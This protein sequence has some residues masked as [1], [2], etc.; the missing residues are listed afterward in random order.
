MIGGAGNDTYV[1]DRLAD[2]VSENLAR[3]AGVD[4]VQFNVDSS[5]ALT[6]SLGGGVAGLTAAKTYSSIENLSL[7]GAA[8]HNGIGTNGAN[9]LGGNGAANRLYGLGGNDT[10]TGGAGADL[11]AGGAGADRFVLSNAVTSD[12]ISDFTTT[13][14]KLAISQAGMRIGNGD[15]TINGA[16][17]KATG[18]GFAN[19]AELVIISGNISGTISTSS[20]AAKIGSATSAYAIGRKALF[21]V[22]NGTDSA[23]FLFSASDA[24]AAVSATE[25]KLLATLTGAAST[26]VSD[27]LFVS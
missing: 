21:A 8:A 24:N 11:L 16:V 10:L 19:T 22:D 6:V 27:Y 12:T 15:T 13:G 1:V 5:T 25:L 20:A 23:L 2:V 26:A 18:G 9:L 3:A 4:T 7:A 17:S 14:D